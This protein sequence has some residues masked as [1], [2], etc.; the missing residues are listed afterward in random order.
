METNGSNSRSPEEHHPRTPQTPKVSKAPLV[1]SNLEPSSSE[2]AAPQEPHE[3]FHEVE[4]QRLLEHA[5][6]AMG[7]LNMDYNNPHRKP[8]ISNGHPTNEEKNKRH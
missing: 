2:V 7:M 1:D 4:S 8:P 6:E 3:V 5:I